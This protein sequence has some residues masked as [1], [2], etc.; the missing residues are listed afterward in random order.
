MKWYLNS[1]R[2]WRSFSGRACRKEF[3]MFW[4]FQFIFA[5]VFSFTSNIIFRSNILYSVFLIITFFPALT[6]TVRRLHDVGKS[7]IWAYVP[8]SI[9]LPQILINE[10]IY[11]LSRWAGGFGAILFGF[12]IVLIIFSAKEGKRGENKWGQNP[13]ERHHE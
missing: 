11:D 1:L 8:F 3:W 7:G 4:L 13:L 10:Y 2:K 12:G 6:V 5:L 9:M